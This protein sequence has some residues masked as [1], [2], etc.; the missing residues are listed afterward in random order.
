MDAVTVEL[1]VPDGEIDEDGPF[2]R[3]VFHRDGRA[4]FFDRVGGTGE[5]IYRRT[6]DTSLVRHVIL[7]DEER[8]AAAEARRRRLR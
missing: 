6:D 8:A 7:I 2:P 3:V 4:Y 1:L 5:A